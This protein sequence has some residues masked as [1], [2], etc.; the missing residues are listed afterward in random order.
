[1]LLFF[2]LEEVF[3]A[4]MVPTLEVCKILEDVRKWKVAWNKFVYWYFL[5]H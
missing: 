1:M 5:Q 4:K 2:F 3:S